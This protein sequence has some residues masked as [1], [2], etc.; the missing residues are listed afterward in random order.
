VNACIDLFLAGG[1]DTVVTATEPRAHPSFNMIRTDRDGYAS[2]LMPL[3]GISRR[4]D[5]PP[6]FELT[7]LCYVTSPAFVL[8]TDSYFDGR[9]KAHIVPPERAV[10]IDT[11]MDLAFAEFLFQRNAAGS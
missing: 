1:A 2:V 4:Q 5:A 8:A 6:V 9:V 7:A 10:D 3:P 11:E